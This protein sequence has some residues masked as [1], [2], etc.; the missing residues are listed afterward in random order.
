MTSEYGN[1]LFEY[2]RVRV[3]FSYGSETTRFTVDMTLIREGAEQGG[4]TL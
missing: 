2:W 1:E 3:G 4:E